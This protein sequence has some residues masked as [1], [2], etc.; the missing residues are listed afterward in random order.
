MTLGQSASRLVIG[1]DGTTVELPE[2][3]LRGTGLHPLSAS[4]SVDFILDELDRGRGGWVVPSDLRYLLRCERDPEFRDLCE[5]AS[6]RVPAGKLLVWACRLQRTPLPERV[7]MAD[8]LDDLAAESVTNRRR[9]FLIAGNDETLNAAH[10]ELEQRHP[11]IAIVGS[12]SAA[13]DLESDPIAVARL[14]RQIEQTRPDLVFVGL[15]SPFQERVIRFLRHDRPEAWWI[16]AGDGLRFVAGELKPAPEWMQRTG[17]EWVH[18]LAQ[19]PARMFSRYVLQGLPHGLLLLIKCASRGTLPKR[20]TGGAYGRRM[21]RA[22]LVDDDQHALDQLE[23]LLSSRF[24]DLRIESRT[25]PDVSGKFDFYFLDNDFDGEHL[26]GRMASHIRAELPKATIIAFSGVL[27]IDTLK[28]LINVGCDGVCDKAEPS[29]WRPIIELIESRLTDMVDRQRMDHVAFG[30]VR[31]SAHSIER[32]L[33][34][35][36]ER[37]RVNR[38]SEDTAREG[39]ANA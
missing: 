20:K 12:S 15:E 14:S 23:L 36:N 13:D 32:L 16:G 18:R 26:A 7:E 33:H 31:H 29:N 2:V 11:G 22:L 21:P 30:G 5:Q 28:R 1:S 9:V 17:L 4:E 34:D 10:E 24:P 38:E 39:R 19:E 27:D 3:G 37:D 35:W 6:L 8:M 25:T